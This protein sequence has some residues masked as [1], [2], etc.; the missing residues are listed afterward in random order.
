MSWGPIVW[1]KNQIETMI[2]EKIGQASN[3]GVG[4]TLCDL[5]AVAD[6]RRVRASNSTSIYAFIPP[7]SGMYTVS[8]TGSTYNTSHKMYFYAA[9]SELVNIVNLSYGMRQILGTGEAFNINTH[10]AFQKF[11]VDYINDPSTARN[12]YLLSYDVNGIEEITSTT[13]T[14]IG[15]VLL[16]KD[17]PTMIIGHNEETTDMYIDIDRLKI[18]YGND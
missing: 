2:D 8:I 5:T 9:T 1:L 3:T 16:K 6:Y 14:I 18:T 4:K 17:E 13:S 15:K 11:W 12:S 7:V 10:R